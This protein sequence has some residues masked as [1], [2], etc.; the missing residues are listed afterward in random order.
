MLVGTPSEFPV[1]NNSGSLLISK[2]FLEAL[3]SIF[4]SPIAI[5]LISLEFTV[6]SFE[7]ICL[8]LVDT[9]GMTLSTSTSEV[10]QI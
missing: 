6:P 7:I 8:R 9:S 10:P 4:E 3:S 1:V 2:L 5:H